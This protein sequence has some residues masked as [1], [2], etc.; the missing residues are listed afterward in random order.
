MGSKTKIIAFFLLFCLFIPLVLAQENPQMITVFNNVEE[1]PERPSDDIEFN[2]I[3]IISIYV[4]RFTPESKGIEGVVSQLLLASKIL[5][6]FGFKPLCPFP[7][8]WI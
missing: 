3:T 4:Y 2:G 5:L 6:R 7:F 8:L 1:V